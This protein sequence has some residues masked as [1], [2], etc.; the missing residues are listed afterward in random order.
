MPAHCR[1]VFVE[2]SQL[3]FVLGFSFDGCALSVA[4]G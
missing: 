3:F 2:F 4:G 1:F